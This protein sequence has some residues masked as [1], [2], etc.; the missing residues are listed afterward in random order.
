MKRPWAR[1]ELYV[2]WRLYASTPTYLLASQFGRS[3]SSVYQRAYAMGLVKSS[4]YLQTPF[5]GR[6]RWHHVQAA[7]RTIQQADSAGRYRVL[8]LRSAAMNA[9]EQ[10]PQLFACTEY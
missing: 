9:D 8:W 5:C 10:F 3:E 7:E 4:E 6:G 1:P 2:L